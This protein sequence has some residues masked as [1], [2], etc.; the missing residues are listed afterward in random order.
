MR[1]DQLI[2]EVQVSVEC[3]MNIPLYKTQARVLAISA[4]Y[5]FEKIVRETYAVVPFLTTDS[6]H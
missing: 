6:Y 2:N 4:N 5:K 1:R 3:G